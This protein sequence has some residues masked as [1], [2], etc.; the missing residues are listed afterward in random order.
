MA[1]SM[2]EVA[3]QAGVSKSTVSLVLNNRP[4]TSAEMRRRVLDA[5]EVVGYQL[6]VQQTQAGK[7]TAPVIALVH[8]VEEEPDVDSGLTYLYLS[9]RNGIQRFTQG[10]NISVMLVTSY[11]DD[12]ADSLSY[13]LLTQE[14]RALD[15][16]IL[17][18]PQ[19]RRD[20]NL[21]QRVLDQQIPAVILGRSWSDL[22]ISSV[23]QDHS[24][25]AH[26]ILDHLLALGHQHIGFVAREVDRTYDWFHWRLAAYRE[27]IREKLGQEDDAYVAIGTDVDVAVQQLFSQHPQVT[28]LFA[29]H[30]HI[31]YQ[32]MRAALSLGLSV[33]DRLS[34]VGIDGAIRSQE[35]LP[36]LTTV[37]FPHEE[38]GYLAAELLFKQIENNYLRNAHLTVRSQFVPG[39]SCTAP[40]KKKRD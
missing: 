29:L 1:V 36:D 37:A 39:A 22:P 18:G 32:A 5:A 6:P 23:S 13:Q 2:D 34:I 14:E 8:C 12:N 21:I 19:L 7:T 16:L 27:T 26:L 9:Y 11:R 20:S 33:P 3:R 40:G 38:V 4:G 10:R 30:D 25:Q 35:G 31:A 24:E 17:M 15:G 28:A